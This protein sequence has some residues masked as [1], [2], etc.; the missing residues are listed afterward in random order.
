MERFTTI[1]TKRSRIFL[2]DCHI[3]I[4]YSKIALRRKISWL[5]IIVLDMK[6]RQLIQV[7]LKI[8]RRIVPRTIPRIRLKIVV[9]MLQRKPQTALRI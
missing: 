7:I 4:L 8:I 1:K 3:I 2:A 9:R 6:T 5:K